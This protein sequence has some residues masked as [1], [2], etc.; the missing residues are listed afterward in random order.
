MAD[1]EIDWDA[2]E[3][4]YRAGVLSNRE[5]AAMHGCS[6]SGVRKKAKDGL[7][8][9]DLKARVVSRTERKTLK[10][11]ALEALSAS[12]AAANEAAASDE[13]IVERAAEMR[14]RMV[15]SHRRSAQKAR[16][17]VAELWGELDALTA[18]A[19]ATLRV[20]AQDD[21]VKLYKLTSDRV[22]QLVDRSTIAQRLSNALSTLVTVERQAIGLDKTARGAKDD[23]DAPKVAPLVMHFGGRAAMEQPQ[24][25]TPDPSRTTH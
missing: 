2:V 22:D 7:W 3:R 4:D 16:N 14:A 24:V 6:E 23:D 11:E 9:R 1:R 13:E 17:Q 19:S 10:A 12:A 20:L 5:I 15:L 8:E 25:A 18:E 21:P